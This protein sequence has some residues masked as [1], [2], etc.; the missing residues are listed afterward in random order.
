VADPSG[1]YLQVTGSLDK[2]NALAQE[3]FAEVR[4]DIAR[5]A[6]SGQEAIAEELDET[7]AA[8]RAGA[9]P[10][11]TRRAQPIVGGAV[12]EAEITAANGRLREQEGLQAANRTLAQGVADA[13]AAQTAQLERQVPILKQLTEMDELRSAQGFVRV[14]STAVAGGRV[15]AEGVFLPA[16]RRAAAVGGMMPPAPEGPLRET[17]PAGVILPAERYPYPGVRGAPERYG[18]TLTAGA[19][20]AAE[21]RAAIRA[22]LLQNSGLA[23][24]AAAARSPSDLMT[25]ARLQAQAQA[26]QVANAELI[27]R[28]EIEAAENKQAEA[29][30]AIAAADKNAADWVDREAKSREQAAQATRDQ[31]AAEQR[32]VLLTREREQLQINAYKETARTGQLTAPAVRSTLTQGVA[33]G[34]KSPWSAAQ[35]D[36]RAYSVTLGE[37]QALERDAGQ[38]TQALT[39]DVNRLGLAQAQSSDAMRQHGALT[40]EWIQALARGETTISEVGYQLMATTAKFAGWAVA[41]GAVFAVIG[42]L[43]QVKNGAE[44]AS[45]GVQQLTR[46]IDGLNRT[47]ASISLA[48]LSTEVN[49]PISEASNAVFE[50]SRS[51]HSLPDA[52][53]GAKLALGAFKLDN[54]EVAESV[55][56]ITA[57]TQ[58]F[59][60]TMA[61]VIPYWDEMAMAQQKFNAPMSA[62]IEIIQN[63]AAAI[64]NAGGNLRDYIQLQAIALKTTQLPGAQVAA[65]FRLMTNQLN[66]TT[67]TG[68]T[69]IARLKQLGINTKQS[70]TDLLFQ[71]LQK[72]PKWSSQRVDEAMVA[73]FGKRSAPK[74]AAFLTEGEAL[75]PAAKRDLSAQGAQGAFQEELTKQLG[76][77]KEQIKSFGH[78]LQRLGVVA[79]QTGAV[80]AF[81]KTLGLAVGVLHGVG[82]LGTG[83]ALL[84]TAAKDAGL[85]ITTLV[86]AL[87]FLSRTRVGGSLADLTRLSKIPGV[88]MSDTT[89]ARFDLR[90]GTRE[91]QQV[92]RGGVQ[93]TGSQLLGMGV[94]RLDLEKRWAAADV[95]ASELEKQQGATAQDAV[96]ARNEANATLVQINAIGDEAIVLERQHVAQL[97]TLESLNEMQAKLRKPA[98]K[99]G[100]SKQEVAGISAAAAAPVGTGTAAT[101]TLASAKAAE[102]ES[103]GRSRLALAKAREARALAVQRLA[104]EEGIA[105]SEVTDAQIVELITLEEREALAAGM[106][107]VLLDEAATGMKAVAAGAVRMGEGLAAMISSIDPLFAAMFVVPWAANAIGNVN[108]KASQ[109]TQ[110]TH[111]AITETASSSAALTK[112]ISDLQAAAAKDIKPK[113]QGG[114]SGLGQKALG[115]IGSD[116]GI[117]GQRLGIPGARQAGGAIQ[118]WAYGRDVGAANRA[119]QTEGGLSWASDFFDKTSAAFAKQARSLDASAQGLAELYAI[120]VHLKLSFAALIATIPGLTAAQRQALDQAYNNSLQ[121]GYMSGFTAAGL[122]TTTQG[123]QATLNPQSST[124]LAQTAQAYSLRA[125]VYGGL[126]PDDLS[127]ATQTAGYMAIRMGGENPPNEQDMSALST[128]V[129][130]VTSAVAQTNTDLLNAAKAPGA[131]AQQAQ[132][133]VAQALSTSEAG[134]QAIKAWGAAQ[135]KQW[136]GSPE[137][138]KSI[139][140]YVAK[141]SDAYNQ[142]IASDIQANDA[143][144]TT[145]TALATSKITGIT[146]EAG[147]ERTVS[148][149]QGA[150]RLL[151]A[152]QGHANQQTTQA[153]ADQRT[154]QHLNQK[155]QSQQAGIAHTRSQL[156]DAQHQ[157]ATAPSNNLPVA[158]AELNQVAAAQ[159]RLQS[160]LADLA[161]TRSQLQ[162]AR[163]KVIADASSA[164][165]DAQTIQQD[166]TEVNNLLNQIYQEIAQYADGLAQ[167]MGQ[168]LTLTIGGPTS[169][170]ADAAIQ[171]ATTAVQAADVQVNQDVAHGASQQK[172]LSDYNALQRDL[173]SYGQTIATYANQSTASLLAVT[174]VSPEQKLDQDAQNV[175]NADAALKAAIASGDAKKTADAFNAL[176]GAQQQHSDDMVTYADTLAQANEAEAVAAIPGITPQADLARAQ[177]LLAGYEQD[178]QR[179]IRNNKGKPVYAQDRAKIDDQKRQIQQ[180]NQTIAQLT[181]S[182][183]QGLISS[184]LALAQSQTTDPVKQAAEQ[185]A[186]DRKLLAALRPSQFPDYKQYLTARNN[187]VA[188]VGADLNTEAQTKADTDIQ[189]W[190]FLLKTQQ[191]SDAQY[192]ELL[193]GLLKQKNLTKAERQTIM[194][195]IYDASH[196]AA[197]NLNVGDIKLPTTYEVR[198]AIAGGLSAGQRAKLTQKQPPSPTA[199]YNQPTTN[200][201]TFNTTVNKDADVRKVADAFAKMLKTTNQVGLQATGMI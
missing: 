84:P 32:L 107:A 173:G 71:V 14:G 111:D 187:A 78:E 189:N 22:Q 70:P 106:T 140:A 49:V 62:Q 120:S 115:I 174:Q 67:T 161:H 11:L 114:L 39:G 109:A 27:V 89:R 101:A 36:A 16:E 25:P 185:T 33:P 201:M 66:P 162:G 130:T 132:A 166:Q 58:Q 77:T 90:I 155:I 182:E 188:K 160:Q 170:A 137:K 46:T 159:Q 152:D 117:A 41:A 143:L 119:T 108:D 133:S 73:L 102:E 157:L 95:E 104:L 48:N 134:L 150:L 138:I 13:T 192:I 147:I 97:A 194:D 151:Q 105:A 28:R 99:G 116:I 112:Q 200:Y 139:N 199:V 92:A 123:F 135:R 82:S 176:L 141:I 163:Q 69:D 128:L 172:I 113:V 127:K 63:S 184:N 2:F 191:I 47:Q 61:Q 146:P 118:D 131:S 59:G 45:T 83:L 26:T 171:K 175:K 56:A 7:V 1:D 5:L 98:R 94:Q 144:I 198:R 196:Q 193:K 122:S 181:L 129:G 57:I 195:D 80:T 37:T 15:S 149:A 180:D 85:A 19:G 44:A 18:Q 43:D 86:A 9:A 51:F 190:Q 169:A 179:D 145:A 164:A 60:L 23:S 88:G 103:A 121:S 197:I 42:A 38:A 21:E 30:K 167:S 65:A 156:Q 50:M 20:V 125:G 68:A 110:A 79:S 4:A 81:T 74:M 6:A 76:T 168:T 3:A 100:Y 183:T 186:A 153:Q 154:V 142:A 91:A 64:K 177:K 96:A 24:P 29:L 10:L 165:A 34:E 53:E 158:H 124:Q 87:G 75:V 35:Q 136:A 12:T 93:Q 40:T 72:A 8:L 31:E 148:D 52:V 126:S 17:S 55:D 178:L 54:V